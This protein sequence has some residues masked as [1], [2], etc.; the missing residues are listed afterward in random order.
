[1]PDITHPPRA[2]FSIGARFST[3]YESGCIVV[4]LP[5]TDGN[6]I[7]TDSDGVDCSYSIGMVVNI[8]R[9]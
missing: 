2:D 4:T 3:L 1:M 7:G 9:N 8:E 5:D 6:F